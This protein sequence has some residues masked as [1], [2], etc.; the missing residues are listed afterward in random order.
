M[1]VR[2]GGT[3]MVP[4]GTAIVHAGPMMPHDGALTSNALGGGAV[5]PSA[6]GA[7]MG[8]AFGPR[9]VRPLTA[10]NSMGNGLRSPGAPVAGAVAG[11]VPAGASDPC[12]ASPL[13]AAA[14]C[15][16]DVIA[17]ASSAYATDSFSGRPGLAVRTVS[18]SAA[19]SRHAVGDVAG[20]DTAAGGGGFPS[21]P[22]VA[23]HGPVGLSLIPL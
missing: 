22:G 18:L 4:I 11:C 7:V 13:H 15:T 21:A 16:A 19:D 17:A 20:S 14:A 23:P 9:G 2:D 1:G 12:L 10:D 5:E 3:I 6:G 8:V